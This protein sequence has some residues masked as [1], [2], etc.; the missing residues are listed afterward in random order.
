MA[1]P[2]FDDSG[3]DTVVKKKVLNKKLVNVKGV[4]E[5]VLNDEVKDVE[6]TDVEEKDVKEKDEVSSE[7]LVTHEV[8]INNTE[9][10]YDI[11]KYIMDTDKD[12]L[13]LSN[14]EPN[15]SYSPIHDNENLAIL[16]TS[17]KDPSFITN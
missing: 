15:I 2:D 13:K 14:E 12:M 10:K 11:N 7:K 17:V 5:I 16:S 4:S 8:C 9:N 6:E 1:L 3:T